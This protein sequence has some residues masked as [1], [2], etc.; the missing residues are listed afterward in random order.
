[1]EIFLGNVL[2]LLLSYRPFPKHN[3]RDLRQLSENSVLGLASLTKRTKSRKTVEPRQDDGFERSLW[4]F[5]FGVTDV[6]GEDPG[7]CFL[8]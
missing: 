1:M 2:E 4:F 6:S 3:N 7:R 8:R 5:Y